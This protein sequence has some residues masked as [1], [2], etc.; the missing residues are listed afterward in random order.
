MAFLGFYGDADREEKG[1]FI[2]ELVADSPAHEAGLAPGDKILAIQNVRI[3]DW[4]DIPEI[5]PYLPPGGEIAIKYERSEEE[6]EVT[7]NAG[8]IE[9]AEVEGE[10]TFTFDI[11]FGVSRGHV[12]S[13]EG[14]TDD[15]TL[16]LHTDNGLEEK[17]IT[18]RVY[19]E[20]L[21]DA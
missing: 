21:P 9:I 1:A 5:V 4:W 20:F 14:K 15:L 12:I 16:R 2:K 6:H 10:G 8:T 3:T 18:S 11:Y 13:M 19:L 7:L 17:H